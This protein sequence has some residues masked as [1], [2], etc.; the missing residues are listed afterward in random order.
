MTNELYSIA[1]LPLD[2]IRALL[3]SWLCLFSK[4]WRDHSFTVSMLYRATVRVRNPLWNFHLR[5]A[6]SSCLTPRPHLWILFSLCYVS[7]MLVQMFSWDTQTPTALL[8]CSPHPFSWSVL[9]VQCP[10]TTVGE[11]FASDF[12]LRV[13]LCAEPKGLPHAS[14]SSHRYNRTMASHRAFAAHNQ[15]CR[16]ADKCLFCLTV[17]PR[18]T[19]SLRSHQFTWVQGR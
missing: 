7:M 14:C 5:Q 19:E 15:L 16:L 8:F 3:S 9:I 4:E 6:E 11:Y 12:C 2:R 13:V 17:Y 18:V 10:H 1:D